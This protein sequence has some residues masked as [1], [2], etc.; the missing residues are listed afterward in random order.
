[1]TKTGMA[2]MATDPGVGRVPLWPTTAIAG[3]AVGMGVVR[4]RRRV[5]GRGVMESSV[6]GAR[7]M[8]VWVEGRGRTGTMKW[9]RHGRRSR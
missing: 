1:M 6:G 7:G 8:A 4:W 5:V 3:G 2:Q 9:T